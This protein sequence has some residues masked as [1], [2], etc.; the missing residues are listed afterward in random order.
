M[1]PLHGLKVVE[2]AGIGP[3]PFAA[4]MLAD[5]GAD[6]VRVDRT[7]AGDLGIPVDP[8]LDLMNRGKR[9]VVLDLKTDTGRKQALGLIERADALLEGFRPGVMERLGLGPDVCL[10]A[11]PALVYGRIT[12]WGQSGP[13]AQAAGHDIDYIAISG[14]LS[15]I[16][17]AGEKPL[18]PLNLIG[19]FGGGGVYLALGVV[20]ALWEAQRSGQGQVVDAAMIDG[21]ASLMT[22]IHGLY[23]TGQWDDERGSNLLDGGAPWYD[24]Y[25]TIDGG[26]IAVGA[27]E[28][29]FYAALLHGLGLDAATLPTRSDKTRWP[30][31]RDRFTQRFAERTRDEWVAAFEGLDA[32]VAPVL[33]LSEAASHPHVVARAT[34]VEAHGQR[35]PAPAPRFSRTVSAIGRAPPLPGEHTDEVLREWGAAP[36]ERR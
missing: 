7:N 20:C 3:G 24:T 13:L 23:N 28:E 19:D 34:F 14:A 21:A 2:M 27:I 5:M 16:G 26:F 1:G 31:L 29:R 35:Q 4:M 18:P 6:V 15:A 8:R 32:C 12:G 33:G 17:R 22:F 36:M 9:S 10:A 11:N 30:E 25:R